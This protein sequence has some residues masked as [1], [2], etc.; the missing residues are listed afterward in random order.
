MS[1]IERYSDGNRPTGKA[2]DSHPRAG[3]ARIVYR[4]AIPDDG[5][6]QAEVFHHAVMQGAAEHYSVEQR[7]AWASVL[8]REGSAWSARQ[9]LHKTIV[10]ACDG[11]CVGFLEIGPSG[12]GAGHIETLYVWPSL[13]RRGIGSTLLLHAQR[14]FLEQGLSR[15]RI[16][17]SLMLA[18]RLLQR[19]WQ[20]EGEE[21]V[22]RGG[23]KLQ[24]IC[25]VKRLDLVE[26]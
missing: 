23:E 16:G 19:G 13:A 25:L 5:A 14:V 6:D 17:A 9:L 3:K 1:A 11:R 7:R 22:E 8:P 12:D 20:Q 4:D 2:T 15:M 26:T 21:C 18:P 24:R 10:A